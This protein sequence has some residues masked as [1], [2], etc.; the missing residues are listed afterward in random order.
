MFAG[1][2]HSN[3]DFSVDFDGYPLV[4]VHRQFLDVGD[5]S[6][7][8][9]GMEFSIEPGLYVPGLGGF[10]HSDTVLVTGDGC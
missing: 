5:H 7:L 10:R 6:E 9:A 4:M 3:D 8:Q 1:K 2:T